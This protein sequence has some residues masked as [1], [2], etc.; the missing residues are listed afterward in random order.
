MSVSEPGK[1]ITPWAESGLKNPIPP[2][3]N[4]ATGRAGFDQG[5]SAINMTAKEAGGIPPFGQDFNGIFYE[6]TN[7]LRYMQAGGQPTFDAALATAIGGYPKGAMVLGSDGMSLWQSKVDSNSTDPNTD[8]SDWVAFDI[9]LKEDLAAPDGSNYI[10]VKRTEIANSVATT[11]QNW[12]RWTG[13]N[14]VS[15]FGAD[16]TFTIDSTAAIKAAIASG[17]SVFIPKGHYKYSDLLYPAVDGQVIAGEGQENT[18]LENNVNNEPLFC[19]GNPYVADG[20]KQWSV[21]RDLTLQGNNAGNTL[22][23]IYAPNAALVDG[24]PN[25]SGQHEGISSSPS[26]FY[27]GR[28]STPF[29]DWT[30]AARGNTARNVAVLGVKGGFAM[31]VSAW[32]FLGEK[33][34][35]WSGKQGLRQSGAANSNTMQ[36]LYISAMTNEG[37]IEPDR[38]SSIPTACVYDGLIVQQ[39]GLSIEGGKAAVEFLKGQGS[40]VTG[41]YLERNN[42]RGA[43]TDVYIGVASVGTVINGIRHRVDSGDPVIVETQGQ[44]S[45]IEDVVYSSNIT[46]AVL[47][48]GTDTRTIT[49]VGSIISAGG[50]A[51]AGAILDTST[52]QKTI[53]R[54]M[55]GYKVPL[56]QY[57]NYAESTANALKI[58]QE[59]STGHTLDLLSNGSMKFIIDPSNLVT[60]RNFKFAHNGEDGAETALLTIADTGHVTPGSDNAQNLGSASLRY[61]TVYAGTGTINTSDGREKTDLLPIDDVVLDAWGDVHI[62]IY[63][64]LESI[65]TKGADVARWHPGV[66]SQQVRDAFIA[67]GLDGTRYGLLCYDEW[68]DEFEPVMAVRTNPETGEKE[69][70]ETGEMRLVLAA[71]HRWGIRPDQCLF[72]EA[73]YQRRRCDRIEARLT[74]IGA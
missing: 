31:H 61:G 5:F 40:I 22:W 47:V 35:L 70:Y 65:R 68:E 43:S 25:I 17:R 7:I 28:T 21:L 3:A 71:G 10:G 9:G 74:S 44:G 53:I 67:H 60:G 57:L 36:D 11:L 62:G 42:E 73:A 20:A 63:Q 38:P 34:R 27:F 32:D 2:A 23:G 13:V 24:E 6:V 41:L 8:P 49:V 16:P 51:S 26:N 59:R 66:I 46:N 29:S 50:T 19:F 1:I 72:L 54:D 12:I 48:S 18:I 55:I 33:V 64:W 45:I 4:P 39:C 15:E 52:G 14:V 56:G 58:K 69:A 37:L 30:I